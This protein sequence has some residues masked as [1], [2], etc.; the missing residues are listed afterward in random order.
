MP[1]RECGG[2]A[3]EKHGGACVG[4][5]YDQDGTARYTC[6]D[7]LLAALKEAV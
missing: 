6:L 3:R 7:C 2:S 4:L 1:C 5:A